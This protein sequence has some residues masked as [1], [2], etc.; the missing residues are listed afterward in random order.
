[1]ADSSRQLTMPET[2]TILLIGGG[3]REHALAWKLKQSPRC[4]TIWATDPGNGGLAPLVK[5][6]PHRWD[7]SNTFP[8]TNWCDKQGIDLV[9]VGPEVPLAE[10]IAD[11]LSTD[12]RLVFGPS[13]EGARLEADKVFAKEIMREAS[14]PT[15]EGRSFESA[16]AA[17]RYLLRSLDRELHGLG[18]G[19]ESVLMERWLTT[20]DDRGEV[21][22]P[23]LEGKLGEV[24]E[25]RQDPVVIKA[26]GL[27]AGKGVVV[28]E[29]TAQ[30]LAAIDEIMTDKVFG[31]AGDR[32]IIEEKLEGQEVSVLA[33]TDGETIWILDPCQDHKQ[34][35]EGDVGPNTGGMG[36]YCPTPLLDEET[37]EIIEQTILLPTVDALR[38][39]E[40]EFRGVLYAGLMLTPGGPKVLEFNVR[41]GDPECQP[42]MARL[43][44]D[45]VEVLWLTAAGRLSQASIEFDERTAC[46]VVLCSEGY[47]GAYEKG[48]PISGIDD[49]AS[50]DVIVFHAGTCV[51]HEGQL[52][53][54]G[55]RVAGV[56]AL[57]DDLPAAQA[58]ANDAAE[59]IAFDGAFFRRDIGQRVADLSTSVPR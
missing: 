22:M 10:G 46:C 30:A 4:G 14:V 31:A 26:S 28:C 49:A 59:R 21:P 41:F 13:K 57:A 7:A 51:N 45:L 18:L 38:R 1:M 15:A 47:P 48:R 29:T 52:V 39:R 55:G 24:I 9:V 54:N 12:T 16:N 20:A 8:L 43:E 25:V 2:C 23:P 50:D 6:C 37:F 19:A 5:P 42:L 35:G 34:V 3:G 11:V 36:A 33:L 27:A 58:I 53:T 32:V 17:R 44:G 40:I 56:T